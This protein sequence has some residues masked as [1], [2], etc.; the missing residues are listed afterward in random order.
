MTRIEEFVGGFGNSPLLSYKAG[1]NNDAHELT[2]SLN[3]AP[4]DRTFRF[5]RHEYLPLASEVSQSRVI[6]SFNS[7]YSHL[8]IATGTSITWLGFTLR[9]VTVGSGRFN[10]DGADSN[11]VSAPIFRPLGESNQILL[12]T[13]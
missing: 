7:S 2:L 10:I 11:N 13:L 5:G 9:G 12:L 1:S 8:A 4:N 6:I 3:P